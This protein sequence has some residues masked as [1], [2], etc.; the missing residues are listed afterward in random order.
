MAI[1]PDNYQDG[2]H[3]FPEQSPNPKSAS[4]YVSRVSTP[5]VSESYDSEL[6]TPVSQDQQFQNAPQQY[7]SAPN[8]PQTNSYYNNQDTSSYYQNLQN[9]VSQNPYFQ[10]QQPAVPAANIPNIVA[11]KKP[12]TFSSIGNFLLSKWWLV[13]VVV[14]IASL[15]AVALFTFSATQKKV[16]VDYT[17]VESNISGPNTSPSGS[18][19]VWRIVVQNRESVAIQQVEVR[20]IFDK[21]FKYSKKINPDPSDI[22]GTIYKFATLQPVGQGASDA[23]ISLEG[24]LTGNIDEETVMTGEVSYTPAP[25]LNK[26]NSRVTVP[27]IPQKTSITAPEITAQFVSIQPTIQ[28]GTEG[29]FTLSFQNLSERELTN[30]RVKITYPDKSFVYSSSEFR[31]TTQSDPKT[32]PDDGNNIWYIP[33]LPRQ[34]SQILKIRGI[35]NG[36]EGVKQTFIAEIGVQ[37]G[38]DY[39]TI[40]STTTDV[41]ITSQPLLISSS[42]PN[43][44]ETK[45]FSPGETLT[46]EV[47]YQNKSSQ[48]LSNI[49]IFASIDDPSDLLDYSS[50]KYDDGI[51][52]NRIIQWRSSGI[53]KLESLPPQGK[54]TINYTIKVK[55]SDQ[56]IKSGLNQ[57]AYT[58]KPNVEGKAL[59]IPQVK[60]EGE[61]YKATGGLIA[62]QTI[63][64]ITDTQIPSTQRLYEVTW[65]LKTRQNK[66]DS[67]SL[68]SGTNLP[69]TAWN[70]ASITPSSMS[71]KLSYNPLNGSISWKPGQIDAY[72]GISQP[73]VTVTFRLLVD[74]SAGGKFSETILL[75]TVAGEGVDNFTLE[76]YNTTT[77][78]FKIK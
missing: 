65:S 77:E 39:N 9:Q 69:P 27:I 58:I 72:A 10:V 60:V 8:D 43:L 32:K 24:I 3:M 20:L 44:N 67:V 55:S 6:V 36:A 13:L 49:E 73:A 59:N 53:K 37:N 4:N 47:V 16:Q 2:N 34:K 64:Q 70:Q 35:L 15:V 12:F 21:S 63:K 25:L 38:S 71:N 40:Q 22:N 11:K 66:V 41:T 57:T 75:K 5:V 23:V 26:I 1:R 61:T 54:G 68:D 76:K 48:T 31:L 50:L 52:N 62:E 19:N 14:L 78:A 33:S 56:F 42:I 46:F 45:L 74:I 30:L 7:Q 17:K 51:L 18:P 29:E 28:S